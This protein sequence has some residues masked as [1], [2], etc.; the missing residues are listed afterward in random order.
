[1]KSWIKKT[2]SVDIGK[3]DYII[4]LMNK[5]GFK[6]EER[7]TPG[8]YMSEEKIQITF[9]GYDLDYHENDYVKVKSDTEGYFFFYSL[10][11]PN[12]YFTN[13]EE[14]FKD[15]HDKAKRTDFEICSF[16]AIS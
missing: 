5:I 10:R 15:I 13:S 8:G 4:A 3:E 9:G 14:T 1:M 16:G 11:K 12:G 6:E 7:E 2:V